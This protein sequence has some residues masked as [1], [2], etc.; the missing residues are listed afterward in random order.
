MSGVQI[1]TV[2]QDEAEQR[3]DR[4]F[5]RMFPHVPQG[6]IEKMCRKGEIR[7]EGG[8]VKP[9]TRIAP[10]QQVRVPPLPEVDDRPPPAPPKADPGKAE[11]LRD[12]VIF[13]DDQILVINKP[14]G[15]AV[16]GGSKLSDHLAAYLATL[17]FGRE[18]DP[19][20]IHRLDK[21]TSGLLVLAR[22][23][24]SAVKLAEL[25]RSRAVEK[26]YF[27]A[28]AGRPDP[29][30]GTI[31]FGLVKAGRGGEGEKM[32]IVH[33]G[34]VRATDGAKHATTDYRVIEQAGGRAAW[35]ALRPVT[36]RT[37]QLRAHMAAL[38]TPIAGDGKYGG[39]GQENRGDGWGAGLGGAVSRKLHLHASR[40]SFPHPQTGKMVAFHAQL[41]DHMVRTWEM[42]GWS[43]RDVPEPVFEE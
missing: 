10:G 14:P 12:A 40:L 35:V 3:L 9:A 38:G 2:G 8:R 21:D 18:D 36:G 7:V 34:E 26:I 33:P 1:L 23:G 4:W 20:L 39:R 42:F 15:L 24:A 17:R 37:H 29:K 5:R 22:T 11:W 32:R 31:H 28:V 16:Q 30:A 6:R 25:F 13:R 41:P 19:R 27:A 43:E